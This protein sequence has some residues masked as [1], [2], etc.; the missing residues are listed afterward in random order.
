MTVDAWHGSGGGFKFDHFELGNVDEPAQWA[1]E[2]FLPIERNLG[3]MEDAGKRLTHPKCPVVVKWD[4]WSAAIRNESAT[5]VEQLK[6][7]EAYFDDR[8]DAMRSKNQDDLR[9]A[10][11]ITR[12]FRFNCPSYYP[13]GKQSWEAFSKSRR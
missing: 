11:D 9:S 7:V 1:G 6:R 4:F 3:V 12:A 8:L 13:P 2:S 10:R 5:E